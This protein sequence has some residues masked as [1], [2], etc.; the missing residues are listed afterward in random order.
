MTS[1]RCDHASTRFD[2]HILS[3]SLFERAWARYV[4]PLVPPEADQPEAVDE[5]D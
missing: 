2:L 5:L 1:D 4:P 3:K